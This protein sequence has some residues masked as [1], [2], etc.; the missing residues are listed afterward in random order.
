MTASRHTPPCRTQLIMCSYGPRVSGP[1]SG[2][3]F[4][5]WCNSILG[6]DFWMAWNFMLE[7]TWPWSTTLEVYVM[8]LL[9]GTC[10]KLHMDSLPPQLAWIAWGLL[11]PVV[12]VTAIFWLQPV[13]SGP[14]SSSGLT[15][16]CKPSMSLSKPIWALVLKEKYAPSRIWEPKE[17]YCTLFNCLRYGKCEIQQYVLQFVGGFLCMTQTSSTD[18]MDFWPWRLSPTLC[19]TEFYQNLQ[20]TCWFWFICPHWHEVINIINSHDIQ[21]DVQIQM[22]EVPLNY[23][24][25]ED[26]RSNKGRTVGVSVCSF[27]FLVNVTAPELPSW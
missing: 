9:L 3:L 18:Y 6:A 2:T 5:S 10:H 27:P 8:I 12:Q 26:S 7:M 23:I 17:T 1:M 13:F 25:T 4:V 19:S 16:S 21:W 22:V 14:L 24:M 20:N 15:K 11:S